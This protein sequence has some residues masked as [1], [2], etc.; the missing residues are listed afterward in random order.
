MARDFR[1]KRPTIRCLLPC[2]ESTL[3]LNSAGATRPNATPC[4]AGSPDGDGDT[5]IDPLDNCPSVSNVTQT[6]VDGDGY[7]DACD[8]CPVDFNPFQ[9]DT[10]SDTVGDCC[11]G[12][13]PGV[14]Q[15]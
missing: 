2:S 5:L 8:N 13:F 12:D 4:P 9:R 1:W 7:G 10:D 3:G 11:D 15:P 14:C 6:D